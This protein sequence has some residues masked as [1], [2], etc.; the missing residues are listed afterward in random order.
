MWVLST[1]FSS[2]LTT[3]VWVPFPQSTVL[4]EQIAP[5]WVPHGVTSPASKPAPPWAPFSMSPQVLQGACSSVCF[6]WGY[7]LL[8]GIHLLWHVGP[9]Q[10]AGGSLYPCGLPCAAGAQLPHHGLQHRLQENLCYR[11]WS[12]SSPSFCTDLGCFSHSS[13]ATTASKQ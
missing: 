3:P 6:P 5:V 2:S 4:Q 1:G 7:S 13:L 8:L 10:A 9:S 11:G 12:T